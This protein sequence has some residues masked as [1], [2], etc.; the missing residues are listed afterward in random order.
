M[1][2]LFESRDGKSYWKCGWCG[3][4]REHPMAS[5]AYVQVANVIHAVVCTE[6]CLGPAGAAIEE[7][8]KR[9][10]ESVRAGSPP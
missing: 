10:A 5:G 4:E 3:E 2:E 7:L 8:L 1:S 6:S 9:R